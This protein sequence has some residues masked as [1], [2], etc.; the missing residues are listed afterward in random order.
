M[1]DISALSQLTLAATALNNLILVTPNKNIGIQ[2]QN[3]EGKTT[4]QESILFNYEGENTVALTSDVTDHFVEDNTAIQDQIALKP[5]I[6][7]TNGFIGELNDIAP[8]ALELLKTAADKL[9][10]MSGYLPQVSASAQI[11]YNTAKTIYD[12]AKA[13]QRSAVSAWT[14]QAN[15]TKQQIAFEQFYGYW[16]NRT[17]FTVQT[18]W[19]IFENCVIVSLRAIQSS[20]SNSTSDFEV[21]FKPMRFAET[22]VIKN[23]QSGIYDFNNFEGR[24]LNQ[25]SPEINIGPNSPSP[26]IS[27]S[28]VVA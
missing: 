9:V 4:P 28:S 17:L 8:P 1:P 26:S 24:T 3:K 27:L 23:N 2:P 16:S 22:V 15:K 13:T 19:A 11:A 20:E 10:I 18:P 7:T 12:V 25:G 5:V 14:S 6:I 21:S